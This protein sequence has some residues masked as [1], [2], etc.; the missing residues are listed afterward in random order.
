MMVWSLM[1]SCNITSVFEPEMEEFASK[2]P[3]V[4]LSWYV[5]EYWLGGRTISFTF[6]VFNPTSELL[7]DSRVRVVLYDDSGSPLIEKV[8]D[9]HC[10]R[11]EAFS[12]CEAEISFDESIIPEEYTAYNIYM[13]TTTLHGETLTAQLSDQP[14]SGQE[15]IAISEGR[16]PPVARVFVEWSL[17]PDGYRPGMDLEAQ[18]IA[19]L[20]RGKL[21]GVLAC[22]RITELRQ[23][24]T[25]QQETATLAER[26]KKVTLDDTPSRGERYFKLTFEPSGFTWVSQE[27]TDRTYVP[28][29]IRAHASLTYHDI[30]IEEFTNILYL[31]PLEVNDAWWECEGYPT[32]V[33]KPGESCVAKIALRSL[34]DDP[35]IHNLQISTR[36]T[37]PDLFEIILSSLFLFL[38]CMGG[39]C[40]DEVVVHTQTHDLLLST[41]EEFDS[42]QLEIPLHPTEEI[43]RGVTFYLALNLNGVTIWRGAELSP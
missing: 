42:L 12:E 1:L 20:R 24:P 29:E 14:L 33:Y 32:T 26:C 25:G 19:G 16:R 34:A 22:L 36:Y 2:S 28:L 35:R 23:Y 15:G 3:V 41:D 17:P 38:P 4:G 37:E 6:F 43:S 9:F 27:N 31:P 21:E 30:P 13:E 40:E 5:D 11:I 18:M 7:I 39:V 10:S 8:E